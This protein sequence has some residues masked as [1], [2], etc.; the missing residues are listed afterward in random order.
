MKMHTAKVQMQAV[1]AS[2]HM[3]AKTAEADIAS[4]DSDGSSKGIA[5][6]ERQMEKGVQHEH[7][8]KEDTRRSTMGA[9]TGVGRL[10]QEWKFERQET[11]DSRV[12][13]SHRA[14]CV[15]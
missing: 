9:F 5:K 12:A 14:A 7:G 15:D 4:G 1:F 11:D 2:S 3:Q 13:I 10:S 6:L 8:V